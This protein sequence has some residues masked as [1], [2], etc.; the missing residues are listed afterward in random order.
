MGCVIVLF[1]LFIRGQNYAKCCLG[2][3]FFIEIYKKNDN[4]F[5]SKEIR[6]EQFMLFYQ[7]SKII[8]N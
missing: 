6:L 4:S 2:L 7:T 3:G 8:N 1:L 5:Y